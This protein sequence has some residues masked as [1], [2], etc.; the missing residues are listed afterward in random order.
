ML[1]V[2]RFYK[3][4]KRKINFYTGVPDSILKEFSKC[5]E[6]KEKNHFISTNEGSA[7]ALAIGNYLSTKKIG[8]VYLQNSGLGNAINPLISIA[9]RSVYSIPL[10]LLVG[11]RGA[12]GFK[13]EPQHNSKGKITLKLLRNLK[14]KYL[15]IKNN[16][17]LTKVSKL[18]SFSKKNLIPVCLIIKPKSL[19][20]KIKIKRKKNFINKLNIS[21][22]YFLKSLLSK[23][24]KN[25]KIVCTTGY[26]SR[27][28][29]QVRKNYNLK[30]GK[31]F[32]LVGGMGHASSVALGSSLKSKNKVNCLDGDGSLLMHMGGVASMGVI[33]KKNLRYFLLNNNC[34]ESVGGQKTISNKLNFKKISQGFNFKSYELI[35]NENDIKKLQKILKKNGPIFVEVRIKNLSMKNLE[36]PKKLI[37]IKKNFMR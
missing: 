11:W 22:E 13:D 6:L 2:E 9:E 27:E 36:R 34:H 21:R 15:I 35:K 18:I 26:T 1:D 24:N 37:D 17:D 25:E 8:L 20:N 12:P 19:Y 33:G 10:L 32:Y 5:L 7:V 28:V 23:V 30:K 29:Y 14:I 16:K 4:I 3:T 31:D